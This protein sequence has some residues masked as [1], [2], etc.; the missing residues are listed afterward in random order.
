MRTVNVL[1][2]IALALAATVAGCSDD[3]DDGSGPP[4]PDFTADLAASKEVS[5][6]VPITSGAT[7]STTFTQ[8]GSSMSFTITVAG[9]SST[10][11]A[12]HIH[13]PADAAT[14][15]AVIVPLALTTPATSGTIAT[16]TF[17]AA[18]IVPASGLTFDAVVAL[19]QS[20]NAYVNVHTANHPAGEI[21]GQVE[22][23][24]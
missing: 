1:G 19:M 16:G 23:E 13:G 14:N 20:G 11:S 17:T 9:L 18:D 7:G 24:P 8:N 15:A 3:D 22:V 10:P 2:V 4:A 12:A 5:P 6:P 21:R